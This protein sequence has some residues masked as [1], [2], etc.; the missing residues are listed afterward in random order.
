L[1]DQ[2]PHVRFMQEALAEADA[3]ALID[4][5]P[6]GAVVVLDGVVV[7]RGRNQPIGTHDPTAH[8]EIVA[9]R[10]AA[11]ALGN[12]RLTGATIYVTVEPCV[13]CLGALAHARIGT[14]V[15]GAPEPKNG[16]LESTPGLRERAG[17]AQMV[18]ISGVLAAQCRD[19]LQRFFQAKRQA[20]GQGSAV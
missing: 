11:A 8:A 4:E 2:D 12:Y 18:V 6:I 7:G 1:T 19:R 17:A 9:I 13:M 20:G 3:A 10:A 14:I 15:Y 5:V 16:A